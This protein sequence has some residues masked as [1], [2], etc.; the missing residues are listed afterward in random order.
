ML[1]YNKVYPIY[2][3][4]NHVG[5]DK[6]ATVVLTHPSVSQ[7]HAIITIVDEN[8]HF[9]S[10]VRSING[11]ILNGRELLPMTLNE[12]QD[13]DSIKFAKVPC[14]YRRQ[15]LTGHVDDSQLN[16]TSVFSSSTQLMDSCSQ[17]FSQPSTSESI[18]KKPRSSLQ[19]PMVSKLVSL[20]EENSD[21]YEAETQLLPVE[22]TATHNFKQ[23]CSVNENEIATQ[24]LPLLKENDSVHDAETQVLPI[25]DAN[26][27][28]NKLSENVTNIETV[29]DACKESSKIQ[30]SDMQVVLEVEVNSNTDVHEESTQI[31]PIQE[32]L[33]N[34]TETQIVDLPAETSDFK[35]DN[36]TLKL[37][38]SKVQDDC[39]N[40]S[41]QDLKS[42][43]VVLEIEVTG[44]NPDV[45][46]DDTQILPIH[47]ERIDDIETQIVELPVEPLKNDEVLENVLSDEECTQPYEVDEN[48]LQRS[49]KM[50][51]NNA[52]MNESKVTIGN[53]VET[54][55]FASSSKLNE[56]KQNDSMSES[57]LEA[58]CENSALHESNVIEE[59]IIEELP[60]N[61]G[62]INQLRKSSSQESGGIFIKCYFYN[63][64]IFYNFNVRD[65]KI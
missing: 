5:R 52:S 65:L 62:S 38:S 2:R 34:D 50:L 42:Q 35:K 3:G 31:F 27:S 25:V 12:I 10:E 54:D 24:I 28:I 4:L 6:G 21:I 51:Q 7:Y 1:I 45:H 37:G 47:S 13:G 29:Q 63:I 59:S 8:Q 56:S 32:E 15:T 9:V 41:I 30:E 64:I 44:S 36:T 48:I 61:F 46:N 26:D 60:R 43:A 20:V 40:L 22:D 14:L 17:S 16:N 23:P 39:E 49:A 57:F 55:T 58:N 53:H 19:I 33:G 11:T 18:F